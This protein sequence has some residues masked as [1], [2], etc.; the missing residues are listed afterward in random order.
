MVLMGEE[1]AI[2]DMVNISHKF[3]G[4]KCSNQNT[5]LLLKCIWELHFW[6]I[7]LCLKIVNSRCLARA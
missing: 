3:M 2:Y 6:N 4:V 5:F 7:T 1:K